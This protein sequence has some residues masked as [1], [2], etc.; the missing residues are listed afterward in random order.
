[1]RTKVVPGLISARTSSKKV[2][3][4]EIRFSNPS[5]LAAFYLHW[6]WRS[7]HDARLD[8]ATAAR[9][10]GELKA[11]IAT[12][13]RLQS[14][15]HIVRGSGADRKWKELASLLGEIFNAPL[16]ATTV[17]AKILP[18]ATAPFLSLPRIPQ[19]TGEPRV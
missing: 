5:N 18:L 16:I 15:A 4:I 1:V 17:P 11:E 2:G 9:T 13:G 14:L 3:L 12:L 19:L 7:N 8:Q 10:I 6:Q